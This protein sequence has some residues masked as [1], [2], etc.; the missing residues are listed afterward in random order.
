MRSHLMMSKYLGLGLV[1][2]VTLVS[3]GAAA[4]WYGGSLA[5]GDFDASGGWTR[6]DLAIGA[7]WD[8]WGNVSAGSVTIFWRTDV[9]TRVDWID[10]GRLAGGWFSGGQDG[11]Q[12]VGDE[13]GY[14]MAVGDFDHDGYKDLAIG[15]PYEDLGDVSDAGCVHVLYGAPNG[16]GPNGMPFRVETTYLTRSNAYPYP[17]PANPGANDWFGFSLSAGD[18]D[19]DGWDDL[20]IGA[21]GATVNGQASAGAVFVFYNPGGGFPTSDEYTLVQGGYY[22]PS[23][24]AEAYDYF[25]WALAAGNFNGD[26]NAGT[27]IGTGP[28]GTP[29]IKDLAVSAPNQTVGSASGA[30][31]VTVYYG[32]SYIN[33][34]TTNNWVIDQSSLETAES[35]DFFGDSLASGDFNAYCS[36]GNAAT[37]GLYA[38]LAIGVPY[39][40][41]GNAS[42]AG[43]VHVLYGSAAGLGTSGAQTW[44][45]SSISGLFI[46]SDY[47]Y[48]GKALATGDVIKDLNG[49]C[50]GQACNPVELVVGEPGR[51]NSDGE[52]YVFKGGMATP[53]TPNSSLSSPV[54]GSYA[55]FGRAIAIG[56]IGYYPSEPLG[57]HPAADILVGLPNVNQVKL[58]YGDAA[59]VTTHTRD[60][61]WPW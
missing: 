20:A 23:G 18:F 9:E 15:A 32:R 34:D 4:Q 11:G 52:A 58:T 57:S 17:I 21:P 42:N 51:W 19:G 60:F 29:V 12:E 59:N 56:E 27:S 47:A 46:P 1:A 26:L 61:S 53:L 25:G 48:F 50:Q 39:E 40:G 31:N 49:G 13:F 10:Q 37:C 36:T 2:V 3:R 14:A 38:D 41:V 44:T 6:D 33:F 7:P 8:D 43:M 35:G 28:N 45:S 16:S 22:S 24:V 54:T 55:N 30:G 5:T